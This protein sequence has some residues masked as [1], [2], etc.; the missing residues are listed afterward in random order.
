MAIFTFYFT[1]CLIGLLIRGYYRL[2]QSCIKHEPVGKDETIVKSIIYN[3]MDCKCHYTNF[4]W[5]NSW[6][7]NHNQTIRN[8]S[9]EMYNYEDDDRQQFEPIALV[10]MTKNKK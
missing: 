6:F 8:Y 1:I 9:L 7:K 2:P 5:H 10:R 3:R 4:L